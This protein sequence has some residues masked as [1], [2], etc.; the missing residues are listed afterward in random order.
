MRLEFFFLPNPERLLCKKWKGSHDIIYV[1]SW[2]SKII[3]AKWNVKKL[4]FVHM[5]HMCK[6]KSWDMLIIKLCNN[7]WNSVAR[8]YVFNNSKIM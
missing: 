2:N 8:K 1:A 6:K 7:S 3:S 5:V 4:H